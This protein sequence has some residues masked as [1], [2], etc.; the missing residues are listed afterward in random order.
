M[1]DRDKVNQEGERLQ[2]VLAH[3]GV[4]S[5]RA[6]EALIKAGR[7][8]VNG[9]VVQQLGTKVFPHDQILLDDKPINRDQKSCYVLLNKPPGVITS[10]RDPQGRTTVLDLVDIPGVRLYPVGRLD[11]DTSGLLLL[12]NDGELAYR[13]MHP[14]F[15]I[16]KTYLVG[17]RN[18]P[19]PDSLQRLAQGVEL[20]DGLT[21]PAKVRYCGMKQMGKQSL[22]VVEITIHEGRNRQVRRMFDA[23]GYPVVALKRIRLGP[24]VL[25]KTLREGNYR[26]LTQ[27]EIKALKA[28]VGL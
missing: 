4:A 14:R 9:K 8:K 11:Y 5:R 28:Q 22:H 6:A 16:E 10:A 3:A 27:E 2:K 24:L 21:A 17:I 26:H 12:T 18:A 7:V 1:T 13:L 25:D 23:V 19:N 20:E 15:E